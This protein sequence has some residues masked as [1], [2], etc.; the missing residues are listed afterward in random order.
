MRE[1]EFIEDLPRVSV[2]NS[3]RDP[4]VPRCSLKEVSSRHIDAGGGILDE[5]HAE[6]RL[7]EIA[8]GEEAADVK[9]EAA[10][11][12]F[13]DPFPAQRSREAGMLRGDRIGVAVALESL[14]P[15]CSKPFGTQTSKELRAR[16]ARAAVRR[17]QDIALTEKTA[18]IRRMPILAGVHARPVLLQALVHTGDDRRTTRH[19]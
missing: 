7:A 19:R 14:A 10:N 1:P 16:R 13:V 18:M 17:V 8:R 9:G 5:R 4:F 15:D 11:D 12:D 2:A 6:A 3:S